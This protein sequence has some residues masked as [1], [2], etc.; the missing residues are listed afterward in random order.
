MA[1]AGAAGCNYAVL[2]LVAAP[3]AAQGGDQL[4]LGGF[5]WTTMSD[6]CPTCEEADPQSEADH[7]VTAF[8]L[9]PRKGAQSFLARLC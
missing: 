9:T 7:Q 3:H 1:M 4:D 5:S 2:A 8:D 6:E